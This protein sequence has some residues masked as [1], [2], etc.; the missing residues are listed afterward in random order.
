MLFEKES[1]EV[2]CWSLGARVAGDDY[3]RLSGEFLQ[4]LNYYSNFLGSSKEREPEVR[5]PRKYIPSSQ[6]VNFTAR[7]MLRGSW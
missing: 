7:R 4:F 6:K 3:D 5:L 1:V 2:N